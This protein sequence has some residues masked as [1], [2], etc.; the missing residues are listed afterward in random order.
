[1]KA[2]ARNFFNFFNDAGLPNELV[3][4]SKFVPIN[5]EDPRYGP[6]VSHG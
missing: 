1:L 2:D 6:P 3:E 5:T 4:D